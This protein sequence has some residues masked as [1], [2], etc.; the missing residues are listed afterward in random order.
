MKLDQLFNSSRKSHVFNEY[1]SE[2]KKIVSEDRVLLEN[3]NEDI[4]DQA[5]AAGNFENPQWTRQLINGLKQVG[6]HGLNIPEEDRPI[7][8]GEMKKVIVLLLDLIGRK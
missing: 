8:L 5:I 2:L 7:T 6:V 1:I 3:V 4:V